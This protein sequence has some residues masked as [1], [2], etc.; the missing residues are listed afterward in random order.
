MSERYK[1]IQ[2]ASLSCLPDAWLFSLL[3]HLFQILPLCIGTT[4][5]PPYPFVLSILGFFYLHSLTAPWHSKALLPSLTLFHGPADDNNW[6][7]N[8]RQWDTRI[9]PSSCPPRPLPHTHPAR[10][11]QRPPLDFLSSLL[12]LSFLFLVLHNCSLIPS[13]AFIFPKLLSAYYFYCHKF[14]STHTF[15]LSFLLTSSS[16]LYS[17]LLREMCV[18]IGMNPLF[19]PTVEVTLLTY[20]FTHTQLCENWCCLSKKTMNL[21]Q[22][23][24]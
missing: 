9:I 7:E 10:T 22:K 3:S 19:L 18:P 12:R 23:V 17:C 1:S 21:W 2:N 8:R 6:F 13:F 16:P 20:L 24:T 11:S 14:C 5:L 4:F 15:L